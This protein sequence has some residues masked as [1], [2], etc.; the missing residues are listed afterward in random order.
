M[1]EPRRQ[2]QPGREQRA[3]L[4]RERQLHERERVA[5]GLGQ[6][7]GAGGGLEVRGDRVEELGGVLVA[8]PF[9]LEHRQAG[10][11]LVAGRGQHADRLGLQP[12]GH[13]R[14]HLGGRAIEPVRVLDDDQQRRRRRDLAEQVERGERDQ[15]QVRR[16][17]LGHPERGQDGVTLGRGEPVEV[18]VDGPQQLV[19]AGE[20]EPRLRLH[21]G[22]PEHAHP[23]LRGLACRRVEQ[24]GLADPRLPAHDEAAAPL[25]QRVQQFL[26]APQLPHFVRPRT[27]DAAF[28][29]SDNY[30]AVVLGR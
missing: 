13:E 21:A 9:E 26:E 19:Q 7:A 5:G 24:R 8:E 6:H 10:G 27:S 1:L 3:G 25:G 2:R 23:A 14:Q 22:G 4:E 15:E 17:A 28:C 29:R 20:R 16:P 18:V 11:A 12:P 30:R